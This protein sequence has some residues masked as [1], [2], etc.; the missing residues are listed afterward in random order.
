M[1]VTD[2]RNC[3][4]A[5]FQKQATR[6]FRKGYDFLALEYRTQFLADLEGLAKRLQSH[7]RV[8]HIKIHSG[9]IP[10]LIVIPKAIISLYLRMR[11]QKWETE[12]DGLVSG[13][14]G[15]DITCHYRTPAWLPR[16]LY[17]I[18][19]VEPGFR[20]RGFIP[21]ARKDFEGLGRRGLTAEE[22]IALIEND[23]NLLNKRFLYL[24]SGGEWG[25][26]KIPTLRRYHSAI[27]DYGIGIKDHRFG[28]PSCDR[29]FLR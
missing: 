17:V 19:D 15:D 9:N 2:N 5:S 1:I 21:Q 20:W 4:L 10:C 23:L 28:I 7:P 3:L 18:F 27:L 11:Y 6:L 26:G 14:V 29:W 13:K 12:R 22:G 16:S 24:I 8:K 25:G